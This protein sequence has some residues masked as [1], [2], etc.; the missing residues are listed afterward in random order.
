MDAFKSKGRFIDYKRCE[1]T[2]CTGFPSKKK[3]RRTVRRVLKMEH[4]NS[5][6]S[7][8]DFKYGYNK[9]V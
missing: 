2:C 8:L 5:G 1:Y 4:N 7:D 6:I 3:L 9:M